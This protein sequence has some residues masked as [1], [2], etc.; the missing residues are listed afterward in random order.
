[1]GSNVYAKWAQIRLK[2]ALSPKEIRKR[3]NKI[4]KKSTTNNENN[5]NTNN[6]K[7]IKINTRL[8]LHDQILN[9]IYFDEDAI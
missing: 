6:K 4:N 9:I 5:A 7:K 8:I 2:W 3:K 1:M